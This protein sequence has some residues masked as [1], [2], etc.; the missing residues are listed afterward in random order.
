MEVAVS[1]HWQGIR[2]TAAVAVAGVIAAGAVTAGPASAKPAG[3]ATAHAARVTCGE[4]PYS[5]RLQAPKN[6]AGVV[7]VRKGD[8]WKVWDNERDGWRITVEY[9]YAGVNDAWKKAAVPQDGAAAR[10]HH[11]VSER[12]KQLCFRLYSPTFG[13]TSAVRHTT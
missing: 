2:R 6:A 3:S 7:F 1:R 12:F 8:D 5:D 10:F 9:N 4:S 13:Y 11:N